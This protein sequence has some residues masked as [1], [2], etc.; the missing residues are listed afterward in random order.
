M[1]QHQLVSGQTNLES[2]LHAEELDDHVVGTI[3]VVH[4]FR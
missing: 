3:D 4:T 2:W 1:S